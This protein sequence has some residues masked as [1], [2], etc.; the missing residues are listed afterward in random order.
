MKK[1]K[2]TGLTHTRSALS[3][4]ASYL[5][6]IRT[7][8]RYRTANLLLKVKST[9]VARLCDNRWRASNRTNTTRNAISFKSKLRINSIFPEIWVYLRFVWYCTHGESASETKKACRYFT[10]L[11]LD[12]CL[13][14]LIPHIC[15]SAS[16]SAVLQKGF[17]YS[18]WNEQLHPGSLSVSDAYVSPWPEVCSWNEIAGSTRA[19]LIP[20]TSERICQGPKWSSLGP[21]LG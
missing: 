9:V 8:I 17:L 5:L 12:W 4:M 15:L 20:L 13:H 11:F 1:K 7:M 14:R 16:M 2:V 3:F 18:L 6:R 19:S 21:M 10:I